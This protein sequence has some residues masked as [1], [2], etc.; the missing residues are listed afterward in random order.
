MPEKE[1]WDLYDRNRKPLGKRVV[2]D[3]NGHTQIPPMA[4]HLVVECVIVDKDRQILLTQRAPGVKHH[5][6]YWE[7]TTG[8]VMAGEDSLTG[9][10]REVLEETGLDFPL[11]QFKLLRTII[12][13]V[14]IRDIYV[15]CLDKIN[16]CDVKVME[17][18][19]SAA[20]TL[21]FDTFLGITRGACVAPDGTYMR[22]R[23]PQV[24]RLLNLFG[25]I[26]KTV[27]SGEK[28]KPGRKKKAEQS[29]DSEKPA[30][31]FMDCTM[32]DLL[33]LGTGTI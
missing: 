16:L 11:D 4:Y 19:T 23:G 30:S 32:E 24:S 21:P 7:C 17:G 13:D 9:V 1:Y 25:Q 20:T 12:T 6:G 8:S 26:E 10:H 3:P 28:K 27:S 33:A 22:L 31:T 14:V 5:A 2:R 18:E 29:K 15:I